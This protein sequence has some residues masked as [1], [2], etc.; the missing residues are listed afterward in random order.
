[1]TDELAGVHGSRYKQLSQFDGNV[2]K[3]LIA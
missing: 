2:V 1:M 3:K